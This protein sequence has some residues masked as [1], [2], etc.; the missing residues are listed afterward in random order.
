MLLIVEL[1]LK[2]VNLRHL[3]P[4][5]VIVILGM[6]CHPV[7][8][9]E[10]F[11]QAAHL[12]DINPTIAIMAINCRVIGDVQTS[13]TVA[14]PTAAWRVLAVTICESNGNFRE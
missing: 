3:R 13:S 10:T 6:H 8:K 11:W 7:C 5:S 14:M 9:Q 1:N 4:L 2:L 12:I